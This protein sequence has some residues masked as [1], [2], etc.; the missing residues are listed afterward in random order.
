MALAPDLFN[1]LQEINHQGL[2]YW[3]NPN[4]QTPKS[5]Q[6]CYLEQ[7]NQHYFK[8][9]ASFIRRVKSS[10]SSAR[11]SVWQPFSRTKISTALAVKKKKRI[12]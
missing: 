3:T 10:E 4:P 1:Q 7:T 2:N 11:R 6:R 9:A 12:R 8:P 5:N